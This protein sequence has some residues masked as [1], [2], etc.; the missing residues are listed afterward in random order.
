M[1]KS[2]AI[3]LIGVV[4][5]LALIV[6]GSASGADTLSGTYVEKKTGASLTFSSGNKLEMDLGG[7][8]MQG[9]YEIK[10]GLLHVDLPE[11]G[12]KTANEY[13][14]EG[15]KLTIDGDEYTKK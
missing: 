9:S 4:M 8:K 11:M 2:L 6:C 12:G 10:D 13:K 7:Y 14:L 15:D 1:K 3:T 5:G